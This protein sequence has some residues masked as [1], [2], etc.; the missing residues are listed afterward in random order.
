MLRM[1]IALA[2]LDTYTEEVVLI[3]IG[4]PTNAVQAAET[5]PSPS[6]MI[7]RHVVSSY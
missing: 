4:L 7:S 5:V 3:S 6:H 2:L 1:A